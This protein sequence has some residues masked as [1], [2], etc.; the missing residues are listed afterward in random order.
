MER[1]SG[2]GRVVIHTGGTCDLH[3]DLTGRAWRIDAGEGD[4]PCGEIYIA[5]VE[6]KTNGSVFFETF[7]LDDVK[8]TNVT[9]QIENG[10]VCGSSCDAIANRFA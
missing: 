6:T 7:Y 8:Y 9:L 1:F 2:A 4:L 5:P 3:L 10:E